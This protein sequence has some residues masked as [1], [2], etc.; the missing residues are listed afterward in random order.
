MMSNMEREN[1]ATKLSNL[2]WQISQDAQQAA[3]RLYACAVEESLDGTTEVELLHDQ[4]SRLRDDI[5]EVSQGL[6]EYQRK[7]GQ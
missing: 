6:D 1:D 5:H 7:H 4:L 3:E 2:L